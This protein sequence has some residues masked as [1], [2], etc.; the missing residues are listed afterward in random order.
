M[1]RP[2]LEPG[3]PD[4]QACGPGGLEARNPWKPGALN[5]GVPQRRSSE[6]AG[7]PTWLRRWRALVSF[8]AGAFADP[9]DDVFVHRVAGGDLLD[10]AGVCLHIR[11]SP[12]QAVGVE[13]SRGEQERCA[14]VGVGQRMVLGE[15]LQ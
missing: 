7:F 6:F 12:L 8:F 4:F 11:C 14:L 10:Q 3:T 9:S 1:A 15:V 5:T 13:E 2:G